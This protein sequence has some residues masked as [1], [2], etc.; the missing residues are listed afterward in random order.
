MRIAT[1]NAEW[2][3]PGSAR[4]TA[5]REL[6]LAA[7]PDIIVVTEATAGVLPDGHIVDAGANW[8]YQSTDTARRKVL[9]WSRQPWTDVE[10]DP[11]DPLAGRFVRATTEAPLGSV[12]VLGVCIPW[13]FAHVSTGRRDRAPW[14]DHLNFLGRLRDYVSSG[15]EAF[16]L[17][18]DFNQRFPRGQQPVKAFEAMSSALGDLNVATIDSSQPHLIDHIA[19]GRA[20]RSSDARVLPGKSATPRLS[21]HDGV[22]VDLHPSD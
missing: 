16:V 10:T 18:G 20:Y 12:Q 8:G 11:T 19:H 13:A 17:A 5:I 3:S 1:Y 4:E 2:P 6:L 22:M 21:D 7:A 14:E 15:P 9:M